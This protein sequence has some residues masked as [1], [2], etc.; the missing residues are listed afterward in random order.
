M[1]RITDGISNSM[2]E[3]GLNLELNNPKL[4][5][6]YKMVKGSLMISWGIFFMLDR[7]YGGVLADFYKNTSVYLYFLRRSI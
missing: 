7:S 3:L 4:N 5:F 6:V 2:S 1:N